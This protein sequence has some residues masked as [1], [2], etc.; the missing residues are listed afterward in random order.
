MAFDRKAY[1]RKRY[2]AMLKKK[3]KNPKKR[4]LGGGGRFKVIEERA[5]KYG[6]KNPAAVAAMVGRRAHG[7]AAMTRW[8]KEGRIRHSAHPGRGYIV[9]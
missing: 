5:R 4:K 1:A 3:I 9:A 7:Q 2:L 8:S 6:A